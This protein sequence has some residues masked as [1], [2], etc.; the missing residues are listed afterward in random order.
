MNEAKH[1]LQCSVVTISKL[2]DLVQGTTVGAKEKLILFQLF[3]LFHCQDSTVKVS[4]YSGWDLQHETRNL[5]GLFWTNWDH[6]KD[7]LAKNRW[8]FSKVWVS[9]ASASLAAWGSLLPSSLWQRQR[10]AG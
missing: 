8:R 4:G 3:Q 10:P 5:L 2:I 7:Q 9:A 6:Q 1:V